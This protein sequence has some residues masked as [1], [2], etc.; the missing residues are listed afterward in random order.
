MHVVGKLNLY[1]LVVINNVY[2]GV[3][4][5]SNTIILRVCL[6]FIVGRN[7][8]YADLTL[9]HVLQATEAQFPEAW[10]AADYVPALK[11]YKDRISGRS[12]I[13]AFLRSERSLPFEGN[14]M[15]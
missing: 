11:A 14:S 15:M 5:K 4:C 2:I 3:L 7:F 9:F 10:K 13:A 12:R 6:R 8:C 1:K